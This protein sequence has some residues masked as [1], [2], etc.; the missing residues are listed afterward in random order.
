MEDYI[1]IYSTN[2]EF[3][4]TQGERAEWYKEKQKLWKYRKQ[5]SDHKRFYLSL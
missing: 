2:R 3:Q 4:P 1:L 5:D